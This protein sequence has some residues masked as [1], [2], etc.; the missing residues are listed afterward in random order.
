[1]EQS[2]TQI[3][4]GSYDSAW[5]TASIAIAIFASYTALDLSSYITRATAI[6]YKFWLVC[7][8]I[9]MGTGIWSMHFI[10]M[11][12]FQLP[13]PVRYDVTITL[14]SL[15]VAIAASGFALFAIT[16]HGM[17]LQR[18]LGSGLLMGLAISAMHYTG[19]AAMDVTG[20]AMT[21]IIDLVLL[22][23]GI[24]IVVSIIALW[25][26]YHLRGD[27]TKPP[28][29]QKMI[30]AI[31]MGFA[32][33][34]MHYTGMAATVFSTL[35]TDLVLD[36]V[37]SID[38]WLTA[39]IAVAALL[40][41][42]LAL[43]AIRVD[44]IIVSQA[45]ALATSNL[46]N[47]QITDNAADIIITIDQNGIIESL[48]LAGQRTFGYQKNE[49][50]GQNIT[51][52]MSH[53]EG[54]MHNS[55]ISN[56]ITRNGHNIV[57]KG[58]REVTGV[59][60]GGGRI[61][62]ELSVSEIK[63]A[64]SGSMFI[65]IMRDINE[66]KAHE[67][68][69]AKSHL[70][71]QEAHEHLQETHQQLLQSEKMASIGQLAAGVAH[72]INNPVGYISSNISTLRY[73]LKSIL[74]LLDRYNQ[75]EGMLESDSQ[76]M[77]NILREKEEMDID[78]IKQDI[79][80][81]LDESREGA[82]RVQS[83]VQDLKDFSHVARQELQ[84]A[85]LHKGV[86]STLNIISSEIKYRAEV[87]KE[88]GEIPLVECCVSQLNQVFM[89]I[90]INAAHSIEENGTI[91]IRTGANSESVWLEFSDDGKG[92]PSENL[93]RIFEPF[94]TTKPIGKGTGLG[95]SLSYGII[96]KHKGSIDVQSEVGKGTTFRITL[97]ITNSAMVN[98]PADA[99]GTEEPSA[100]AI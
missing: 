5:V 88:Y 21:Y 17:S 30:S 36:P 8:A 4:S 50:I 72:E 93:Q 29:W 15:L 40:L 100:D 87:I 28:L 13:F 60:K 56:Y 79:I 82:L 75:L 47:K 70:E 37:A 73:Y 18:L 86:D 54:R 67:A 3:I 20:L 66:R 39:T 99:E 38:T 55:Y 31:V 97:P 12:A 85:D 6:T 14:L 53:N 68:A 98:E 11:L 76:A 24:A 81:L 9:S 83:I 45:G 61:P 84:F 96:K 46:R 89:N 7:G 2:V 71:L 10:G 51:C 16:R 25:I 22:S 26:A 27:K 59:H 90:L 33:A 1:M 91:T 78:F 65:G 34:G 42:V 32:I 92:I 95:L 52:L 44:Q 19:M 62:L 80:N 69:L 49:I 41:L 74:R 43:T 48:N 35:Q 94:F 77:K 23:I 58:V 64:D 63:T 57:G